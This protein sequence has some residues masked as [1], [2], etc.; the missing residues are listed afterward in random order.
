MDSNLTMF[1]SWFTSLKFVKEVRN[2]IQKTELGTNTGKRNRKNNIR[3]HEIIVDYQGVGT[4]RLSFAKSSHQRNRR[5]FI[6]TDTTMNFN[7]FIEI[8]SI[9]W[10]TRSFLKNVKAI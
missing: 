4:V 5:L 7:R 1:W 6:T 10:E 8:Y 2:I 9:R 3:Y